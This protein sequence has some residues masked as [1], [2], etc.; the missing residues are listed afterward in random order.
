MPDTVPGAG[1]HAGGLLDSLKSFAQ[2]L[3]ALAQTRLELLASEIEEQRAFVLREMLVAVVAA[4]CLGLGVA[5]AALFCVILVWDHAVA[6]LIVV[7]LFALFFLAACGALVVVMRALARERPRIF[8][9]AIREV[10]R[11]RESLR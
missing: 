10:S 4:F 1:G 2:S 6:R 3:L 8:S 7:G 11:D 9:T 5:F